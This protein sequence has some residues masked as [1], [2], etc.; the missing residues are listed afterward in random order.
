[1]KDAGCTE[2]EMLQAIQSLRQGQK[3]ES[4]SGD[5]N[6]QALSKYATNLVERARA[7][8]LDPVIGRDEAEGFLPVAGRSVR[9]SGNRK[10][11]DLRA[12]VRYRI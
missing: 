9:R 12:A 6:F 1:M 8:K 2:K 4:Q 3:V 11:C 5:E 10:R 7:G